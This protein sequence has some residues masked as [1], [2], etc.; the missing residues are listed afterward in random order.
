METS[1]PVAVTSGALCGLILGVVASLLGAPTLVVA[2]V[3][4]S[5]A[6]AVGATA[7]VLTRNWSTA[8]VPAW[9]RWPA[10]TRASA[11]R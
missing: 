8:S 6:F 1:D 2:L 10:S 11:L 3:A 5:A 7:S 9:L 4:G